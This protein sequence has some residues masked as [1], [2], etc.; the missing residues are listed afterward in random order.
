M[1]KGLVPALLLHQ[2][3]DLLMLIQVIVV[4]VVAASVAHIRFAIPHM[5]EQSCNAMGKSW[6]IVI[7]RQTG[8]QFGM[9]AFLF[10][11]ALNTDPFRIG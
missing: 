3:L 11:G 8:V 5:V 10:A 7:A 6:R 4:V 2:L 9:I 1:H